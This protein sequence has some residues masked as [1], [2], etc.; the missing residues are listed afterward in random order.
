MRAIGEGTVRLLLEILAR[1]REHRAG[2]GDTAAYVDDS[3]EH[4][5]SFGAAKITPRLYCGFSSDCGLRN[6]Q[7]IRIRQ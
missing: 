3:F 7:S 2:V 6:P 4:G 5:A 1:R